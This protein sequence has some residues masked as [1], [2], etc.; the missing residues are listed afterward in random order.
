MARVCP[1]L[2]GLHAPSIYLRS[3][4]PVPSDPS[5]WSSTPSMTPCSY[6]WRS[7]IHR[8]TVLSAPIG[9]LTFQ[10]LFPL[11]STIIF[12]D[13]F[14][15]NTVRCCN[16]PSH[17]GCDSWIRSEQLSREIQ[18]LDTK[19]KGKPRLPSPPPPSKPSLE[20]VFLDLIYPRELCGL[21]PLPSHVV[22]LNPTT[23]VHL[24]LPDAYLTSPAQPEANSGPPQS[25]GSIHWTFHDA[26]HELS[27]P[28]ISH[29]SLCAPNLKASSRVTNKFERRSTDSCSSPDMEDSTE[30]DLDDGN[31][32]EP[33][34]GKV[35]RR[36]KTST[37][38]VRG[39]FPLVLENSSRC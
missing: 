4:V 3:W 14:F 28:Q 30:E 16:D 31:Y 25:P 38:G 2:R 15:S 23:S 7:S 26:S 22:T 21:P 1:Y 29:R 8:I 39:E 10:G 6:F 34:K 11:L 35:G 13:Y 19:Q 20:Y 36:R 37:S 33:I 5:R 27:P 12:I 24:G 17:K 9:I 32:V 18:I